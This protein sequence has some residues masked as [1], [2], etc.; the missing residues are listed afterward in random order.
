MKNPVLTE[1]RKEKK[2]LRSRDLEKKPGYYKRYKEKEC[3]TCGKLHRNLGPYCSRICVKRP[4]GI[5]EET[6]I[7][8]SRSRLNYLNKTQEG[9]AHKRMVFNGRKHEDYLTDIP[10]LEL[11]DMIISQ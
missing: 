7:K 2:W 9:L 5:S 8:K 11:I 3:P 6:R 1:L 10:S 4:T